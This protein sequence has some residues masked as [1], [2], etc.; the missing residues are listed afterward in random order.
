MSVER[1]GKRRGLAIN[2]LFSVVAWIFPIMLGFIATPIL[3]RGLGNEQYGLFA[4]VL[5][6]ISYSFTFGVGKV[7][8]KYIP[9]LEA[10]GQSEKSIEIV[11]ATFWFS[12]LVGI[13][14]SLTLVM[15]AAL[16][17]DRVLLISPENQQ[18][19]INSLYLAGAIGVALML[20][21]VFQFVLQGLHRFDNY[22]TITNLNSLLLG[23]GNIILALNGFGVVVL[24]LW[25]FALVIITA[26]V[27][28]VRAKHLLPGIRL[29]TNASRAVWVTV[30]RYAGNIILYQIFANVL[31]I[32]ERSWVMRKFGPAALT[33]YFVPM[34]LAIY[35]QGFVAS[36]VQAVFPAVNEVLEDRGRVVELYKRANKL[37]LVIVA[38]IV[39][40]FIVCGSLFLKLWMSA[41][42]AS[43]S[44]S[45]LVLHG[46]SF[47]IISI[48]V[49]AYQ[50]A[51][52]FK[53]PALNVIMTGAWMVIAIP[54]MIVAAD[55]WQSDGVAAARLAATLVT[56]PIIAYSERR[57]L[58]SIL[59]R[60]WLAVGSRV[61]IAA[62]AMA[63]AE[64]LIL[65]WIGGS[66]LSL[67][68]AGA[69]GTITFAAGLVATGLVT[70]DD[71]E[72]VRRNLGF[73]KHL[74]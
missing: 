10:T 25:N 44:Y 24:L 71:K 45:L 9:E 59:W 63:F 3:V 12:L 62:C 22:V 72:L 65:R 27:F 20:S 40:N 30:V 70:P 19:A 49:M 1:K 16:I 67:F 50:L 55:R 74:V 2:S 36:I 46:L 35:M 37:I 41:E 57:F 17:V 56:I 31:F 4:I 66:Y 58:G 6:F 7:V 42:V 14:G 48:A 26:L 64:W 13:A 61:V 21:Q 18:T 39:T 47:G 68:A 32:F 34:L 5:G 11:S 52:V 69:I 38:F 8:G 53:F 51:E 73:R 29:W 23:G 60:F 28:F 54:L 15:T 33:F 43:E